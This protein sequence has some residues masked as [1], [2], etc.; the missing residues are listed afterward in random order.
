MDVELST[1]PD[2]SGVAA[3]ALRQRPVHAIGAN[4]RGKACLLGLSP[5]LAGRGL[6][7]V[8]ELVRR[9]APLFS[10]AASEEPTR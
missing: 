3:E 8:T 7:E 2:E 1:P 4:L 6:P 10:G 9:L 5:G